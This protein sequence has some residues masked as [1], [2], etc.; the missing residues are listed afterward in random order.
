MAAYPCGATVGHKC[1]GARTSTRGV[2]QCDNAGNVQNKRDMKTVDK[3]VVA[4]KKAFLKKYPDYAITHKES[5]GG[6]K[7]IC[8]TAR[9]WLEQKERHETPSR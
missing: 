6:G 8:K 4:A 2:A 7:L 1:L 3:L 9:K 5:G